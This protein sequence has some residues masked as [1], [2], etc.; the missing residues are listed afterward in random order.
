MRAASVRSVGGG[1]RPSPKVASIMASTPSGETPMRDSTPRTGAGMREAARAGSAALAITTKAAARLR[2]TRTIIATRCIG[3]QRARQKSRRAS[4][5]TA[6]DRR[7]IIAVTGHG[8]EPAAKRGRA[9]V[10]ET[11]VVHQIWLQGRAAMPPDILPSVESWR[12]A[13]DAT[14][15]EHRLWDDASIG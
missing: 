7:Y 11:I 6:A 15:H 4:P 13:T 10:V 5:H 1:V 12:A 14:G 9:H 8:S 2:A 3:V